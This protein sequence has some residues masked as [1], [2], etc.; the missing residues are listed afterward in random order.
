MEPSIQN[1]LMI[2]PKIVGKFWAH[3]LIIFKHMSLPPN[4][5]LYFLYFTDICDSI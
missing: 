3:N 2:E 5:S 4:V 1:M